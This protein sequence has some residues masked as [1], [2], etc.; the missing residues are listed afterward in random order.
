MSPRHYELHSIPVVELTTD[1]PLLRNDR[2]AVDVIAAASRYAPEIV[3]IPATRLGD[4]FFR[5]KTGVAGQ[6]IQKFLTYRLRVVIVGD[7]SRYVS[8]SSALRDFVHE[9]NGGAH[10]WFV[11]DLAELEPRLHSSEA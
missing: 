10:V 9:C 6:I 2:D 3:I 4:D 11:A 1:G 7:I 5:L 8:E